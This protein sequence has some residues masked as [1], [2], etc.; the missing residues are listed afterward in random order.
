MDLGSRL[1][2]STQLSG[3]DISSDALP[4]DEWLPPNVT[5]RKWNIKDDVPEDLV[6]HYDVVHV[7]NFVYVLQDDE[8]PRVLDSLVKLMSKHTPPSRRSNSCILI[9]GLS[10]GRT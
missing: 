7:R 9:I 6:G 1:P 10:A 4:P 8:I 2:E 5:F 3:L